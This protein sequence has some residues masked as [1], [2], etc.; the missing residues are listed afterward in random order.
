MHMIDI[1]RAIKHA[2]RNL[3]GVKL[4]LDFK[5]P[6]EEAQT[7]AIQRT[8]LTKENATIIC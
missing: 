7:K 8:D 5:R 1:A 2:T 4:D 6:R 3:N